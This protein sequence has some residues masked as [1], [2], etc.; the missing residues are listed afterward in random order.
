MANPTELQSVLSELGISKEDYLFLT[1]KTVYLYQ[2]KSG[3][4]N[5]EYR[6]PSDSIFT[7][8]Y[9]DFNQY[10]FNKPKQ[11]AYILFQAGYNSDSPRM[12]I[13][14]KGWSYKGENQPKSLDTLGHPIDS[15]DVNL[16]LGSIIYENLDMQRETEFRVKALKEDG[17][18]IKSLKSRQNIK[19]K[20][21]GRRSQIGR[22]DR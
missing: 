5:V 20:I 21:A 4:K 22:G 8:L 13:E 15:R 17:P 6:A 7:K 14:L 1:I 2:M 11:L 3:E 10:Q 9:K 18:Q 16:I 12:L 19:L